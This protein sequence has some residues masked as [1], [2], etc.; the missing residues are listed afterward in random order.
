MILHNILK[1]TF[2]IQAIPYQKIL[3]KMNRIIWYE[4]KIV[5]NVG[6]GH[7]NVIY[8][9][10]HVKWIRFIYIENEERINWYHRR[11]AYTYFLCPRSYLVLFHML[12]N[13]LSCCLYPFMRKF[14]SLS[15]HFISTTRYFIAYAVQI[16]ISFL[17]YPIW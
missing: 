16:L 10:V 17:K 9:M 4:K 12:Q 13:S 15:N 7:L 14:K 11:K 6:W 1:H 8:M 5:W 3:P 2:G